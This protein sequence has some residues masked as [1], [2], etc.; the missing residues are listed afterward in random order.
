MFT[1]LNRLNPAH[2]QPLF[3]CGLITLVAFIEAMIF[4]FSFPYFSLHLESQG[5]SSLLIGFNASISLIAVVI[6]APWFPRL[7]NHL[8]YHRFS[9]FAFG[10]CSLA[11]LGFFVSEVLWWWFVLRFILGAALAALW[12]ATEAW[13]N[14]HAPD[15]YRG[16]I[17]AIFQAIYSLGFMF[18]PAATYLTGFTGA[19]PLIF[20]VTLSLLASLALLVFPKVKGETAVETE[21]SGKTDWRILLAAGG[22]L[23]MASLNGVVET[24]AYSML[25]IFGTGLGFSTEF[26]VGILL[27]YTLGEVIIALPIGWLADRFDRGWLQIWTCVFAALCLLGFLLLRQMPWLAWPLALLA[28]GLVVSIYN[29]ALTEMG[30]TYR[31]KNLMVVTTGFSI[32]YGLG[33]SVGASYGGALMSGFGPVGL[34]IGLAL[35][36]AIA[37]VVLGVK[38][39]RR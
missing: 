18:G 15:Q 30:E 6:F 17:N 33:C 25:P 16:R 24:A 22:I 29:L 10:L 12:V 2:R 23:A 28:G 20:M 7:L 26:A 1:I 31:R 5:V 13:L 37:A 34:P 32:A 38:R 3:I 19:R 11:L 36:M 35:L 39:V 14:H 9:L 27:A 21:S 4:G 8:G